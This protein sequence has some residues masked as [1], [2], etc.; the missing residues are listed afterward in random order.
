MIFECPDF[1]VN[2]QQQTKIQ[3]QVTKLLLHE[4]LTVFFNG[5]F[6]RIVY[7]LFRNPVLYLHWTFHITYEVQKTLR[8]GPLICT[9]NHKL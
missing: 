1:G 5:M 4:P 2:I 9:D 3:E 6:Q 8:A 7:S